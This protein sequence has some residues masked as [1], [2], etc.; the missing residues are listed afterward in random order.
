MN[1]W[2]SEWLIKEWTNK[3]KE[4][5]GMNEAI[6]QWTNEWMIDWKKNNQEINEPRSEWLIEEWMS[7]RKRERSNEWS[8]KSM[9]HWMSE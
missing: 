4:K 1:Q 9:N 3:K 7:K 5:A 8:D 2:M 6:N